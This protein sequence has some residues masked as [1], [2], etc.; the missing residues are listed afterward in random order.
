M[1]RLIAAAVLMAIVALAPACRTK[2]KPR[3]KIAEDD[4]Q[5]A[6]VVNVADPRA[7]IQLVSGFHALEN[8]SWRWT[9]R[10]F[11]V[12]LRPHPLRA[13]TARNSN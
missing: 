7:A 3:A 6:S 5:L 8:D 4:G 13:K 1:R 10:Q 2:R 12:T 9:A 11:T